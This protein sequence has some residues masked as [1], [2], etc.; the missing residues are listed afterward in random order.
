MRKIFVA[1]KGRKR[2][3]FFQ[4]GSML[5]W[6]TDSISAEPMTLIVSTPDLGSHVLILIVLILIVPYLSDVR[7]IHTT[8]NPCRRTVRF[9]PLK[10]VPVICN[11][12]KTTS[13]FVK[14][15]NDVVARN[16]LLHPATCDGCTYL[17]RSGNDR[18]A[19]R[20]NRAKNLSNCLY[21]SYEP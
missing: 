11:G 12:V 7:R 10:N 9:E 3:Y 18:T 13:D 8:Y 6:D 4:L 21:Y 16:A 19:I 15:L 20:G 14:H 17:Y 5:C 2:V 1:Q